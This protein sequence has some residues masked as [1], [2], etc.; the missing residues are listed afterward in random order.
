MDNHI[1][2]YTM[3]ITSLQNKLERNIAIND[4]LLEFISSFLINSDD[5][6]IEMIN[7][8]SESLSENSRYLIIKKIIE[9]KQFD[10]IYNKYWDTIYCCG[11]CCECPLW[12][13]D[14]NNHIFNISKELT[15]CVDCK[16]IDTCKK[17]KETGDSWKPVD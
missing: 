2:D 10:N 7:D 11:E 17:L 4:N 5:D 3:T 8:I 12:H 13:N 16:E 15:S 14:C 6:S 9:K 1:D